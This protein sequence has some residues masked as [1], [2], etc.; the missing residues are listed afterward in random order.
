MQ[1]AGAPRRR[2]PCPPPPPAP[3][4][5]L[6]HR[7]HLLRFDSV[8]VLWRPVHASPSPSFLVVTGK[9]SER[10]LLPTAALRAPAFFPYYSTPHPTPST[11][12]IPPHDRVLL[13]FAS[14]AGTIYANLGMYYSEVSLR[15]YTDVADGVTWHHVA[16]V[17]WR[18]QGRSSLSPSNVLQRPALVL[19]DLSPA[20]LIAPTPPLG[21]N[22]LVPL[23]V[24]FRHP[25]A[26]HRRGDG[27][28]GNHQ[29][30][31]RRNLH[32]SCT[33]VPRWAGHKQEPACGHGCG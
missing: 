19:C 1:R 22:T 24:C 4:R 32:L 29:W 5:G 11:S 15:G 33:G 16:M 10:V 17:V 14:C 12:L 26:V 25:H 30:R 7:P 28:T 8:N 2:P 13:S 18:T 3:P 27:G 23:T 31:Q 9:G 21:S 6:Y 20:M